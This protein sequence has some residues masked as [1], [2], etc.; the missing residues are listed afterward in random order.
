MFRRTLFT[1]LTLFSLS[2]FAADNLSM[3]VHTEGMRYSEIVQNNLAVDK[4]V[5]SLLNVK[6][7]VHLERLTLISGE[8]NTGDKITAG[9]LAGAATLLGGA[10][11]TDF[12][13]REPLAEHL[14]EADAQKIGDEAARLITAAIQQSGFT[15]V[16]PKKVVA[17][18]EY[19]KVK[20]ESQNTTESENIKGNL[21]NASYFFGYHRLPELGYKY[22]ERGMFG[23]MSDDFA[24]PA[25]EATGA[26]IA[27][28][29]TVNIVND[30]KVMRVRELSVQ[31]FGKM[32]SRD[33][34]IMSFTLKPDSIDV[35]SGESHKNLD[36][37]AALAPKFSA[38]V[39][40]M[41][42]RIATNLPA[43]AQP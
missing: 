5:I 29:W 28:A 25:R 10:G 42:Q 14:P 41:M 30:R 7:G 21:F 22:R 38:A 34:I 23:A 37:W 31:C 27:L 39:Q 33:S 40:A 26:P 4:V 36:Y 13:S 16:D 6:V 8:G 24:Q 15:L 32:G 43:K 19:A 1:T 20:G 9:L 35:S 2:A 3:D 11:G 12:A 17:L 18:P